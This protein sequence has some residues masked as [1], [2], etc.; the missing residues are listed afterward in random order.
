MTAILELKSIT[1]LDQQEVFGDELYVDFNGIQTSLPDMTKGDIADLNHVFLFDGVALL[2]LFENDGDHWYDRDDL[3]E[4][5]EI[6]DS[7]VDFVLYFNGA[8]ASYA[9]DVSV[10]G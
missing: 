6:A 9:M 10:W 1:C 2:S 4:G 8:G 5:H 3:I 7:P